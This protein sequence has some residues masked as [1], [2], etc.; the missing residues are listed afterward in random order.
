[1][2]PERRSW[3]WGQTVVVIL[4]GVFVVGL[5]LPVFQKVRDSPAHAW[6]INNLR[7]IGI[8]VHTCAAV[9]EGRIPP[10][11]GLFNDREATLFYHLLPYVE[12]DNVWQADDRAA[13]I[14]IYQHHA[15]PT[16]KSGTNHTSY[17]SNVAVFGRKERHLADAVGGRAAADVVWLMERYAVAQGRHHR[18]PDTADGATWLVGGADG[19]E[20]RPDPETASGTAAHGCSAA[21]LCVGLADGSARLL[22]PTLSQDAFRWACDPRREYP[23]PAG[24]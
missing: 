4:V 11:A 20:V 16:A 24:W 10:S 22:A 13:C 3:T 7:Q 9:F 21:G 23:R 17:A 8:G 14:R 15:D 6:S 19:F 12:Q 2:E 1:M 5:L 18:W